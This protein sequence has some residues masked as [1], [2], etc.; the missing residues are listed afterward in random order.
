MNKNTI[1]GNVKIIK[2]FYLKELGKNRNIWIYL[3]PS[4]IKC[5][6]KYPVLYMHDGQNIFNAYTSFSGEEWQVDNTLDELANYNS[7]YEVI[8][9]GIENGGV[10]RLNEY[11]PWKSTI[12]N[13]PS[14]K[15]QGGQGNKYVDS[16]VKTLK[17]YI[18]NNFRTVANDSGI[19]GS[20]MGALI[21]LY[22]SLK[23]PNIFQK[24]GLLS[25]AFWFAKDK[26]FKFINSTK[27]NVNNNF[28]IYC[29]EKESGIIEFSEIYK[30]DSIE[31]YN[32]LKTLGFNS[33]EL[34]IDKDGIHNEIYWAKHFKRI[35][36]WLYDKKS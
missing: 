3:P 17:P 2:D 21:S 24:V 26:L 7:D 14:V 29:G 27:L 6:K 8:V 23:Y 22:A 19:I 12:Q 32:L 33:L 4:Y 31:I 28:F 34:L 25:P 9:I 11:S 10:E 30:N 13:I 35:F 15:N 18:D 5:E 16:I 20:S 36:L 1:V